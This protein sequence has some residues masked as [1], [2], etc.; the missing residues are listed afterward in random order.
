MN[1]KLEEKRYQCYELVQEINHLKQDN[2]LQGLRTER[3]SLAVCI[4]EL[5]KFCF[6]N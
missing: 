1:R 6:I 4:N 5:I 3:D 2:N